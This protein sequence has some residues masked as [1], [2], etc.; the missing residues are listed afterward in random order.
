MA[1]IAAG[2]GMPVPGDLPRGEVWVTRLS[3]GHFRIERADPRVLIS[4]ELLCGIVRA[5]TPDIWLDTAACEGAYGYTAA[6]LHIHGVNQT[7]IYRVLEYVPRVWA[8][9]AEWPD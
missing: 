9:I 3:D 2:T 4:A 5:P 7:V 8:Y 1:V 6:I